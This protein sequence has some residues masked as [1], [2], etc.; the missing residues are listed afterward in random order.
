MKL[1]KFLMPNTWKLYAGISTFWAV[2]FSVW[3][4][5]I[6]TI[7]VQIALIFF[8][9]NLTTILW[10][11]D[12]REKLRLS[13]DGQNV[14]N[15]NKIKEL[16]ENISGLV[17]DRAML[18]NIIREKDIQIMQLTG[19]VNLTYATLTEKQRE[20]VKSSSEE[21]QNLLTNETTGEINNENL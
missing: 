5:S 17:S 12:I 7:F 13:K 9:Y 11:L 16:Q 1:I 8:L 14:T 18:S 3:H 19:L 6:E 20:H 15:D 21:L 4:D 2:I 10:A